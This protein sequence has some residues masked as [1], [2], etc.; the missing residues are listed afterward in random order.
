MKQVVVFV[1]GIWVT[2]LEMTVLRRRVRACGFECRQFSYH[3]L[4]H[5]PRQNAERLHAFLQDIDADV[6]HFVAHSLGGV[7]LSHLFEAYP[8]Q[9]PGRV[10]MLGTPINGSSL[11]RKLHAFP[12][13]RILLGRSVVRGLLGDMPPWKGRPLA[14]I[15]GNR[16][17][18]FGLLVLNRL[19]KPNDG[20][21][22]LRETRNMAVTDHLEVPFSHTQMLLARPVAEAVCEYL[23]TGSF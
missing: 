14:L 16:G 22:C 4:L 7:V 23:K 11:A 19:E 15:A 2:G 12:P 1:H 10:V 6:V 9:R 17:I 18:G 20:T 21:V 3:T 8:M 5:T 13:A